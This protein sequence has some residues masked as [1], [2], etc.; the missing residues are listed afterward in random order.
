MAVLS[1]RLVERACNPRKSSVRF[2]VP[3][4]KGKLMNISIIKRGTTN[5]T[6]W[7][8][9]L[10]KRYRKR[11]MLIRRRELEVD[12]V[13]YEKDDKIVLDDS[14]WKIKNQSPNSEPRYFITSMGDSFNIGNIDL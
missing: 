11:P 6:V 10:D 4:P 14:V 5:Y 7:N 8:N 3:P 1:T 9:S 12:G 2:R 13:V